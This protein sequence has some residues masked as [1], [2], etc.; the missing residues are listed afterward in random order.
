MGFHVITPFICK[1]A[2]N[3]VHDARKAIILGG[4][5][6]LV[7]VV[8]WNLIVL[9]LSGNNASFVSTD[10]IS[11]LLSVNSSALPAVQGFAFSALATSL[12][13]YAVSFPKQI[14]D[15]LDLIFSNSKGVV[16]EVGKV[17]PA[18][19]KLRQNLGN[20]GKV[21]Y[22]ASQVREECGFK[23]L[24]SIVMPFVIA[25][26][27]LIGYFFPSTFSRALDF[28]GIY[29]NCFLFGILPPVMT[30]IYQSKRKLRLGILPGGDCVLLL[31]LTIS[32]IPGI[33]H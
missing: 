5:I 19:F 7:M 24:Q 14:V 9:G 10:P 22:N 26:P 1:I 11:L 30:Y 4:V 25:L 21:S 6:P 29:A 17:G 27:V 2:G 12:I 33:W 3:T 15:T 18:T 8:S 20:E 23:S 16:S 13:G 28:A 32:I 31:L